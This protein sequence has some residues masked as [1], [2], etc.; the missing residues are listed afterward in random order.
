MSFAAEQSEQ[1]SVI[2]RISGL[3]DEILT[4]YNAEDTVVFDSIHELMEVSENIGDMDSYYWSWFHEILYYL[5]SESRSRGR[6]SAY[7]MQNDLQRRNIPENHVG[8]AYFNYAMGRLFFLRTEYSVADEAFRRCLDNPS[9]RNYHRLYIH[10][11]ISRAHNLYGLTDCEECLRVLDLA[12]TENDLHVRE[13]EINAVR[14]LALGYLDRRE[15]FDQAYGDFC[16]VSTDCNVSDSIMVEAY[17][18]LY[19]KERVNVEKY[20][21]QLSELKADKIRY[22]MA[23]AQGHNSMALQ[24]LEKF[25]FD[26]NKSVSF[27]NVSDYELMNMSLLNERLVQENQKL[28]IESDTKHTRLL[29]VALSVIILLMLAIIITGL[30]FARMI[31]KKNRQILA[32][33]QEKTDFVQTIAHDVRT[34]LNAVV[35]FSQLLALPPDFLTQEERDSYA[36]F[37][38]ANA[39]LLTILI[40][41]VL[42]AG[43]TDQKMVFSVSEMNINQIGR[44]AV[45]TCQ[46]RCKPGVEMLFTT[47]AEESVLIKTDPNRVLQILI[48]FL[49]NATKN[50]E[51]GTIELHCSLNENPGKVTYSVTDTGC[52]IP[53]DKQDKIFQRFVKLDEKK[54]GSGLGLAI[55]KQIAECLNAEVK[56]DKSYTDGSRFLFILPMETSI[57]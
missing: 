6:I 17:A 38:G 52:G 26:L 33:N 24:Y 20:A 39:Q 4:L 43:K 12:E 54:Q 1:E 11:L 10:C 35:G 34:P 46:H 2:D 48:N 31:R 57:K 36:E 25:N 30:V 3:R 42:T 47:T 28:Q 53:A 49:S 19:H 51:S 16:R 13:G 27:E 18:E 7:N 22:L 9:T 15:L 14:C 41:D 40:D 55:C 23:K 5:N 56:L 32:S 45:L 44:Q 29:T 8:W 37:I 21:G 50:T